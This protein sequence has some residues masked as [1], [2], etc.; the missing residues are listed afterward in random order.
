MVRKIILDV[1]TGVDDAMAI[2]LACLSPELKVDLITT[3]SGN[4]HVDKT[5]VNSLKILEAIGVEDVP[6]AKGLSKPLLRKLETAEDFHGKDGLGDS[7]LPE[8]K[9]KLLE[10][11]A[12]DLIIEKVMNSKKGEFTIVTTGP[13]TNLGFAL[14]KEPEIAKRV[15]E[16]V[17]MGGAFGISPYGYGNATPVSEFNMYVDPEAAKI[18][19]GSGAKIT[20]VGLDVTTKPDTLITMEKYE[21]IS[22]SKSKPAQIIAKITKKLIERYGAYALHDPMA[23]AAAIDRSL[24]KVEKYHV[25][26][27]TSDGITR[28]QTVAD[29]REWMKLLDE[30]WEKRK[31]VHVCVDVNSEKFLTLFMKR[32]VY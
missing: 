24:F 27:L 3:V 18:V 15:N 6:V 30:N 4:V 12:V 8:P 9:L 13:L 1:D 7:N 28:G 17:I 23:V 32:L 19:L 14:I 26:V 25:E 16:I 5:S 29:R 20:M 31:N 21:E 2:M 11:H 10:K 22:S